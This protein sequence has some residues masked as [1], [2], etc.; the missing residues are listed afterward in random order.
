MARNPMT[1][2]RRAKTRAE[3]AEKRTG[4]PAKRAGKP[5]KVEMD[6]PKGWEFSSKQRRP[7]VKSGK[8]NYQYWSKMLNGHMIQLSSAPQCEVFLNKIAEGCD[9]ITAVISVP[10]FESRFAYNQVKSTKEETNKLTIKKLK[11]EID[12]LRNQL[13]EQNKKINFFLYKQIE[14]FSVYPELIGTDF[15]YIELTFCKD[16]KKKRIRQKTS[17][18]KW[19]SKTRQKTRRT[20]WK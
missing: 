20:T 7:G 4:K 8:Q 10:G 14:D 18:T 5:K 9:E 1:R 15:C 6:F 3:K 2:A 17:R 13:E 19:K 11:T 16:C 12:K